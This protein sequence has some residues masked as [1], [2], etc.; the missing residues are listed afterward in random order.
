VLPP[1][2]L[3]LLKSKVLCRPGLLCLTAHVISLHIAC[4]LRCPP[5]PL[6]SPFCSLPSPSFPLQPF[7]PP[8]PI[9]SPC[10]PCLCLTCGWRHARARADT[11]TH[12]HTHTHSLTHTH[13][14]TLTH[15]HTVR[16]RAGKGGGGADRERGGGRKV[17][18]NTLYTKGGLT[19]ACTQ[20][21]QAV[22][23]LHVAERTACC[24]GCLC[25]LV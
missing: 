5:P 12:T 1:F 20:A 22:V 21:H 6:S 3:A 19:G 25:D 23:L 10:S 11:H 17:G 18:Y 14:H 24:V 8:Q 15:T 16:Q 7:L 2:F 13:T 9:S 4:S